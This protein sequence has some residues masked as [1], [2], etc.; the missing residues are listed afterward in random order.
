MENKNTMIIISK[1]NRQKLNEIKARFMFKSADHT[2]TY[3]L[4]IFDK[5][6]NVD[7]KWKQ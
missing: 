2:I 1:E 6:K 3:L 7:I 4:Y 5:Y